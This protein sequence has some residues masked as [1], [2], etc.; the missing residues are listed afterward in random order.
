M[1]GRSAHHDPERVGD[2]A[3]V[4]Y[5]KPRLPT[6]ARWRATAFPFARWPKAICA[7]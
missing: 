7:R 6:T 3:E 1:A 2:A 5:G 4:N